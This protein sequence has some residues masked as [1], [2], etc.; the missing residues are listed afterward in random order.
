M[1]QNYLISACAA[2]HWVASA[3]LHFQEQLQGAWPPSPFHLNWGEDC[4]IDGGG[5]YNI[6]CE[7]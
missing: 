5:E 3:G 4:D 6:V 7:G 1:I 2:L